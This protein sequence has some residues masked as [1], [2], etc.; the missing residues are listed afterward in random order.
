MLKK[1]VKVLLTPFACIFVCPLTLSALQ[2]CIHVFANSVDPDELA[3]NEPSHQYLHCLPIIVKVLN[4][5]SPC[6][7]LSSERVKNI[8]FMIQNSCCCFKLGNS[9]FVK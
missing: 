7:L 8:L 3:H 4:K 6:Q 1:H 5:N 2:T 9:W